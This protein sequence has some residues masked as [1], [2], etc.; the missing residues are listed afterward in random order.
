MNE[1]IYPAEGSFEDWAYAASWDTLN[2]TSQCPS[3]KFPPYELNTHQGLVYIFESGGHN[4]PEDR[5]ESYE[6]IKMKKE[7]DTL[8]FYDYISRG[9]KILSG[10]VDAAN[11]RLEV[12]ATPSD[13]KIFL[14]GCS[15]AKLF[16][17]AGDRVFKADVKGSLNEGY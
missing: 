6:E 16:I 3:F 14:K 13:T 10:F 8:G 11:P 5:L 1:V 9:I 17:T 15:T 12:T 2:P 7:N 4:V